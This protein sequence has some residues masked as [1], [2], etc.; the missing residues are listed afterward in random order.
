MNKDE[1]ALTVLIS[2]CA[3]NAADDLKKEKLIMVKEIKDN[4]ARSLRNA[5]RIEEDTKVMEQKITKEHNEWV[6]AI[7]EE[8]ERTTQMIADEHDDHRS[9]TDAAKKLLV[10]MIEDNARQDRENVEE[11]REIQKVKNGKRKSEIT[12]MGV[13]WSAEVSR[14]DSKFTGV[15][16]SMDVR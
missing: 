8:H 7:K 12:A 9:E 6:I 15:I 2:N 4:Q 3:E 16:K 1:A 11:M 5:N 10:A 14:I 13:A